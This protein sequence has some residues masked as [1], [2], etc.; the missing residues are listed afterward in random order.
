MSTSQSWEPVI[1][2]PYLAKQT[3][4]ADV[5]KLRIWIWG[6]CP[7]RSRWAQRRFKGPY[8]REA[9]WSESERGSCYAAGSEDG[10]R[11]LSQEI[12]VASRSR[13][14]REIGFSPGAP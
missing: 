8:R 4:Q 7:E 5:I 14:R 11:N 2:S 10:G 3:L 13:K 6:G 12:Q 1:V 9:Q